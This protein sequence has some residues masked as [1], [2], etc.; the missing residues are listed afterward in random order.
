[1]GMDSGLAAARQSG[2]MGWTAPDG[3]VV[4]DW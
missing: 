1:V 2:M 3:I 4:P